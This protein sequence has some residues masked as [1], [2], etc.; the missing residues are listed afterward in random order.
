MTKPFWLEE[1]QAQKVLEEFRRT[2]SLVKLIEERKNNFYRIWKHNN[3]C[4]KHIR[5]KTFWIRKKEQ[6]ATDD[7]RECN[8]EYGLPK[9]SRIEMFAENREVW[10]QRQGNINYFLFQNTQLLWLKVLTLKVFHRLFIIIYFL[11]FF[12]VLKCWI[13]G[14]KIDKNNV[15]HHQ[16]IRW[17]NSITN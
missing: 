4:K 14:E 8:A 17:D 11:R 2:E 7:N 9:L 16:N 1:K 10:L 6:I 13:S 3:L 15:L 5:S 12:H